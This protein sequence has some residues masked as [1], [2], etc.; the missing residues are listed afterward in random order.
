MSKN[1]RP[2]NKTE[3]VDEY[4]KSVIRELVSMI[5]LTRAGA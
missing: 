1:G 4:I 5:D 3:E 2:L